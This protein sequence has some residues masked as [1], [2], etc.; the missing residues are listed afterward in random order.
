MLLAVCYPATQSAATGTQRLLARGI[1]LDLASL[2]QQQG[3]GQGAG[4]SVRD[5]CFWR[6]GNASIANASSCSVAVAAPEPLQ[7]TRGAF[8]APAC[9]PAC[10]LEWLRSGVGLAQ[11]CSA[12]MRSLL[13]EWP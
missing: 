2:Q 8:A 4:F 9:L 5:C 1:L 7:T 3:A 10:L 12:G 13:P 11:G 6:G